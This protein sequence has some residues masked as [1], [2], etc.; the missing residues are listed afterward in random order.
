ELVEGLRA[1][2]E[3]KAVSWRRALVRLGPL[4]TV[5][6]GGVVLDG[7]MAVTYGPGA[8]EHG[9][10]M[11]ALAAAMAGVHVRYLL[12]V[13]W[14]L[15]LSL[16]YAVRAAGSWADPL[17][18][19]G[20]LTLAAAP[21]L[22]V[23]SVRRAWAVGI[24]AAG[25]W[26]LGL[27]P[28]NNLW[29]STA[30]LMADRYLLVPALGLDLLLLAW[31]ARWRAGRGVVLGLV[32]VVFGGLTIAR[33][34]VF[35]D[36]ERVWDDALE[37]QPRSA[38]AHFQAGQA[39]LERRSWI[40]AEKQA[41]EAIALEPRPE[42]LVK[43]R[44]LRASA[45]LGRVAEEE[46]RGRAA[47]EATARALLE[48]AKRAGDLA[49]PLDA[50]PGVKA[51][52]R[53]IQAEALVLW[54]QT[55]ERLH[56]PASALDAYARAVR[57]WPRSGAAHYDLATLLL[58]SGGKEALKEAEG[59]LREAR[60]LQAD[61]LD[62]TLQLG[63]V[64]ALQG[65]ADEALRVLRAAEKRH[66]RTPDVLFALAQVHLAGRRDVS[67]AEAL[68]AEIRR[69][70]PHHPKA[71]RLLSDI[72]LVRA[73]VL[74][75]QGRT[76]RRRSVLE[77]ALKRFDAAAEAQPRRWEAQ[78]GAGDT[79]LE[80]GRY[81]RAR[82]RYRRA[83]A[84]PRGQVWTHR[85]VARAA[86]LEA[87]WRERTATRDADREEAARLVAGA[88]RSS[89]TR[90]DLGLLALGE[91][92][93]W[94]ARVADAFDRGG[95][96]GLLAAGVLRA[97]ALAVTGD[98]AGARGRLDSVFRAL[99]PASA[100]RDVLDGALLLRA[101]LRD[102]GGL[103]DEARRDYALLADRR[104]GDP[105][106]R[107]RLL[108]LD[109]RE[110]GARLAI[111]KGHA[112]DREGL[113]KA[114]A[115]TERATERILAF[116][117]RYPDLLG[118]GLL[119]AEAEMG[120]ERWIPVLRRLNRLVELHP[121]D[122]S[123]YR[124]QATVYVRQ[125]FATRMPETL[126]EAIRVL[127]K[128]QL[129]D[130]R[131]VR[132][133]LERSQVARIGGD[134]KAA[135]ALARQARSLELVAGGSPARQLVGLYGA[136]GR[137]AL[138]RGN[139]RAALQAAAQARQVAPDEADPWVLEGD[140]YLRA[141]K[142]DRAFDAYRTAR[143]LEPESD[144]AGRGLAAAHRERALVFRLRGLAVR[145]PS[146]PDIED[147]DAWAKL[148]GAGRRKATRTWE[149]RRARV[150]EERDVWRRRERAELEAALRLDPQAE[151]AEDVRKRI[152]SL[153]NQDPDARRKAMLEAQDLLVEGVILLDQ[154]RRLEAI[155]AFEGAIARN[156]NLGRAHYRLVA[157]IYDVLRLPGERTDAEKRR[158]T[159]LIGEAFESLQALDSLD[160]ADVFYERHRFR[161]LMNEV[162]YRRY[163]GDAARLSA[164]KAYERYL[165]ATQAA[166]G[167]KKDEALVRFVRGR[168]ASLRR[169]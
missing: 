150:E 43:A 33:T 17:A 80:L 133:L 63:N 148:D 118:A 21:V 168:L 74:L 153:R 111:A 134:L 49:L 62:A 25:L 76:T 131:D 39:A 83:I 116:A 120:Q 55:L 107:L 155:R 119:A 72:H 167:A 35:A 73:R 162:L 91:E 77:E 101:T 130:P 37:A 163:G 158:E 165:G 5:A 61:F 7:W 82:A 31:L 42:I 102:R 113:R 124:G 151:E 87:A 67:R 64:L 100:E 47:A 56:D 145:R 161:G 22:F 114:L 58:A 70:A 32:V 51:D 29:P 142:Y 128:A 12:H 85:P 59:H 9:V 3:G 24:L 137:A 117:A 14:P 122:P 81:R 166:G 23:V 68:L 75:A 115:K 44:L 20:L 108:Q 26:L 27:L 4:F 125:Y 46:G 90:I 18:W 95:K 97:A 48:E 36:A 110:A 140:V 104:P 71:A 96:E 154:R 60:R 138:K 139:T 169:L 79:L 89:A 123:V 141:R 135:V 129:L 84:R 105:L 103:R 10:S 92:L 66:G 19:V 157:A 152:A 2:R 45:L 156:P 28:V 146:R 99:G 1:R 106:P 54:G 69:K 143:E 78:V 127:Q 86:V 147:P 98:E 38:L 93:P 53:E 6:L 34:R 52:P 11:G 164:I 121:R 126:K 136:I 109:L 160:P 65:R 112:D 94:L 149:A 8:V 144:E 50:L 40:V 30:T 132:T 15:S 159:R 88:V 41:A 16:D 13:V 57:T